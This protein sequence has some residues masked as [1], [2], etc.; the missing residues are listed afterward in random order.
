M[1]LSAHERTQ[2]A[3]LTAG[4]ELG[5]PSALKKM[6]RKDKAAVMHYVPLP[7]RNIVLLI[8]VVINFCVF[9]GSVLANNGILASVTGVF[10]MLLT[11]VV[12]RNSING[13]FAIKRRPKTMQ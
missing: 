12:V 6:A 4:L 13:S 1:S 11:A 9:A 8:I 5:D 7:S 2:F 10:G 3:R